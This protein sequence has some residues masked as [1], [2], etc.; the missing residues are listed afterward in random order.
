MSLFYRHEHTSAPRLRPGGETSD[1]PS[2]TIGLSIGPPSDTTGLVVVETTERP[3]SAGPAAAPWS[4]AVRH[5]RRFPPGSGYREIVADVQAILVNL[6]G[7]RTVVLDVTG[8]G[9]PI[10]DL[11][12][13]REAWTRRY[14]LTAGETLASGP[15]TR[16]PRQDAAAR[17]QI[18]LQEQRLAIAAGPLAEELARDLRTFSPKP[19]A[20]PASELAWRERPS[21]DLVLALAL[22]L[23]V[24]D[25]PPVE[26]HFVPFRRP[27]VAF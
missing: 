9:V 4:H 3:E 15:D 25:Q 10:A 24:A 22:A 17:L 21:D 2:Y 20:G 1:A 8:V 6:I 7:E 26:V 13:W 18:V 5:L 27:R 12:T 11:F 23:V 14:R 16:I 19:A